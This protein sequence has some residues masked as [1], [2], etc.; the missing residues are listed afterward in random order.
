MC[1]AATGT[2][3]VLPWRE[4]SNSPLLRPL[5]GLALVAHR[6]KRWNTAEMILMQLLELAPGDEQQ[7]GSLLQQVRTAVGIAQ[8]GRPATATG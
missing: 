8:P 5:H 1:P 4:E 3:G 2:R 6:Q 7:A